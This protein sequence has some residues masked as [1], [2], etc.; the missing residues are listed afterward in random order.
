MCYDAFPQKTFWLWKEI[1]LSGGSLLGKFH[2]LKIGWNYEDMEKND[3]AAIIKRLQISKESRNS[4]YGNVKAVIGAITC[5]IEKLCGSVDFPPHLFFTPL[6]CLIKLHAVAERGEKFLNW[7]SSCC[8]QEKQV[9]PNS[10]FFRKRLDKKN[11]LF[12]RN[13][14]FF[15]FQNILSFLFW[16]W[17]LKE[18]W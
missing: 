5:G 10:Y 1:N 4:W 6:K 18:K 3:K 11:R 8:L 14:I 13:S 16:A 2:L 7:A 12:R 9:P 17:I 15:F